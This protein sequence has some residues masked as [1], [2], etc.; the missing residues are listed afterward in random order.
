VRGSVSSDSSAEEVDSWVEVR[1]DLERNEGGDFDPDGGS[2]LASGEPLDVS[3]AVDVG[4]SGLGVDPLLTS[5]CVEVGVVGSEH[6]DWQVSVS[7]DVDGDL[8]SGEPPLE[9]LHLGKDA[10]DAEAV[11]ARHLS[12]I[13]HRLHLVEVKHCDLLSVRSR[14]WPAVGWEVSS[15]PD[16]G[17]E[18]DDPGIQP[19]LVSSSILS[20]G[21]A[22]GRSAVLGAKGIIWSPS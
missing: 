19:E 20:R 18:P 17:D 12:R 2:D 9:H 15:P 14:P 10:L 21:E 22:D 8:S 13:V 7:V 1:D 16:K 3:V 6:H 11:V 4:V 5:N